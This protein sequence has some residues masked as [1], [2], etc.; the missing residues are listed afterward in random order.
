MTSRRRTATALATAA[1]AIAM[2]SSAPAPAQ[3]AGCPALDYQATL[4]AAASALAGAAPD[5][6]AARADVASLLGADPSRRLALQ[7]VGDDLAATPPQLADARTRLVGMSTTLAYPPHATCNEDPSAAAGALHDV[8]A[9]PGLRH[10]DDAPQQGWVDAI[11]RLLS[12][13]FGRLSAALGATGA[14]LLAAAAV[15]LAG[16]LAWRRWR[17]S[18]ADRGARIEEPAGVGDDPD[19]EWTAAEAAASRGD[20]REAVRRAFRSSLIEVAVGAG[21]RLD[22]AWTTRELLARCHVEADALV[23]MAAAASL[24]ERAWYSGKAVTAVDWARAADANRRVRALARRSR[25]TAG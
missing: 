15:V 24:F 10:L 21:V 17:G 11:S 19:A 20:H 8:Y 23:A 2:V 13:I 1:I 6:A 25:T 18:A 3:A 9:S 16:L 4:A 5:V 14:V 7:P 12:A 22:A